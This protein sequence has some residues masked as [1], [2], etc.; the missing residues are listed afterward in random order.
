MVTD[1]GGERFDA[2]V[3]GGG[4]GG[5]TASTLVAMQGHRVLL[6]EAERFP[7][8]Q[9]GES[10]L[11]A[12]IHGIC[13]MLGVSEDLKEAGFTYKRGGTLRWGREQDLWSFFFSDSF[14]IENSVGYAY[15]VR[16]ATFD[17]ILLKNA[18]RK[19]VDVRQQHRVQGVIKEEGRSVGVTYTD[20]A[21]HPGVARARYVVDASGN[22]SRLYREVGDRIYSKFFENVAL[23]GY[24]TGG[25]RLPPPA[26][27]N[28]LTAAFDGGW[29]W[30]IPL[31]PTLTSVGVVRARDRATQLQDGLE[32]TMQACIDACP[33]IKEYLASAERVT[34]GMY[35]QL[36]VRQDYSYC[37]TRFS[38][39]GLVLVGDAAC[40]IDPLFSTG[41]HLATYSALLA[42]RSINTSLRRTADEARCFAEYEARYRNEYAKFY[43]FL[44]AFYDANRDKDSY[45]WAARNVL[46]TEER[47]N[48]AFV[49]LLAG[50]GDG[51]LRAEATTFFDARH[52]LGARAQ[53]LIDNHHGEDAP[54]IGRTD[55]IDRYSDC[56]CYLPGVAYTPLEGTGL[57]ASPDGFHWSEAAAGMA[58]R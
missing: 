6:L 23:F 31:S 58:T 13:P 15:Q 46:H 28:I 7:R 39:S 18:R 10:L 57:V 38:N 32:E 24:Y 40:F 11:P 47:E 30:Y 33:V 34:E 42:A 9:I 41:V 5:A 16:R 20:A 43:Q 52:Q 54:P 26:E 25:K 50:V 56:F 8:Y 35:G 48:E 4:P 49:R 27:G 44:I 37:N 21:G 17:E 22:R 55:D 53:A 1:G 29:F 51:A 19:G 14:L 12:T 2:I 45:F 3:I 36:R